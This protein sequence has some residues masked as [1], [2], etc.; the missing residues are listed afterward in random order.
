MWLGDEYV[1]WGLEEVED[2]NWNNVCGMDWDTLTVDNVGFAC[3]M[4]MS[5]SLRT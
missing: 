5:L 3:E 4:A 1:I 2:I